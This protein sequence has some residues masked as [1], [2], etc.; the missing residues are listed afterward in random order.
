MDPMGGVVPRGISVGGGDDAALGS[1][2]VDQARELELSPLT[3][4]A[5]LL[6]R[7]H[8]LSWEALEHLVAALAV[9]ADHALEARPFG[10]GGQAQNGVDVVAFFASQPAAVY[11]AKRYEKF[12]AS[13]LRRA[14]LAYAGGSRPFDAGVW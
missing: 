1:G 11:Q 6:L 5:P 14:V 4:T 12:A 8:E 7:T 13:D 2:G 3:V 9:Q 10:R